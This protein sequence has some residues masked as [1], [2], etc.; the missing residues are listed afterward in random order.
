MEEIASQLPS[1]GSVRSLSGYFPHEF[2]EGEVT[3]R[4]PFTYLGDY[5]SFGGGAELLGLNV[6]CASVGLEFEGVQTQ[7]SSVY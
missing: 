7:K 5:C 6:E 3:W 2:A 4:T 1:I